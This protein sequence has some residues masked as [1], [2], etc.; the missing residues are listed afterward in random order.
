VAFIL[1]ITAGCKDGV[2]NKP[3][4]IR[5]REN[6]FTVKETPIKRLIDLSDEDRELIWN[7]AK[8][9]ENDRLGL[10]YIFHYLAVYSLRPQQYQHEIAFLHSIIQ[11]EEKGREILGN[12][13][14]HSSKFGIA[15]VAGRTS[16]S[17]ETH[18]DQGLAELGL[19]NVP[20]TFGH[21]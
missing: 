16:R 10:S 18:R 13:V 12:S 21:L 4:N 1:L 17:Y 20:S 8:L 15:M 2:N 11:Q 6:P 5:I 14:F 19:L 7:I 3:D 9:P